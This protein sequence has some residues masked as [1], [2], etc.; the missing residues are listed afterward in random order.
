MGDLMKCCKTCEFL[1]SGCEGAE[2]I[3][4]IGY[5]ESECDEQGRPPCYEPNY[6]AEEEE[7]ESD[8]EEDDDAG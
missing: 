3:G 6:D 7:Y 1:G 2:S 4:D 5:S 8:E